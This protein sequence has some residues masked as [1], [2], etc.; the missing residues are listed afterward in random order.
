MQQ[1]VLLLLLKWF[2]GCGTLPA[3]TLSGFVFHEGQK[4]A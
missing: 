4:S 2:R 3:R 1:N